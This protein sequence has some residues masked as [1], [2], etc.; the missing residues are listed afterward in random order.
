MNYKHIKLLTIPLI[1]IALFFSCSNSSEKITN[2][3]NNKQVQKSEQNVLLKGETGTIN[4][5]VL[6]YT[7]Y[8]PSYYDDSVKF[9]VFFI[10][11]PHASGELPINLYK[12]YAEKYGYILVASNDSKNGT[13][14]QK[15]NN[16]INSLLDDVLKRLSVD[17]NRIY[18][19]GFSGGARVA[20]LMA[21]NK[22]LVRGCI[23]CGGG[24]M[25]NIQANHKINILTF[26]GNSDFNLNELLEL[27]K[28][29]PDS[30]YNHLIIFDGKHQWPDSVTI[31]DAFYWTIFNEMRDKLRVLDKNIINEFYDKNIKLAQK[32]YNTDNLKTYYTYSKIYDFLNGLIKLNDIKNELSAISKTSK[33]KNQVSELKNILKNE[34]IREQNLMQ[35]YDTKDT[36]WW[37]NKIHEL[38]ADTLQNN[39]KSHSNK[40]ILAFL[41]L[42]SYMQVNN[43]IQQNQILIA[44]KYDAIYKYVNP[45][46]PEAFYLGALIAAKQ[47]NTDKVLKNL[48]QAIAV[49]F[50]DF[51]RLNTNPAFGY[52]L[53]NQQFQN[54]IN[55][56]YK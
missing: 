36:V 5:N 40:R 11:D 4:T 38:A 9:P 17:K 15:I 41:G 14:Y 46:N 28:S 13:D 35:N 20:S 45:D 30:F 55:G 51:N 53:N 23:L 7:Y 56:S 43:A 47:N 24:L 37:K 54:I 52:L 1:T 18:T 6:S 50:D 2:K 48:S 42:V 39:L 29:I 34:Q 32:Y 33:Y 49:G 22:Y 8:L 19:M 44:D 26:V 3:K 27:K 21:F 16:I 10:F 12:S 25:Q 31:E